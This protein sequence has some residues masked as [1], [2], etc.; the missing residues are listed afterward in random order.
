MMRMAMWV[1]L[2]AVD[3]QLLTDNDTMIRGEVF[4]NNPPRAA[5]AV[6]V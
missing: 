1:V 3:S 6:T 4:S 5:Q 2:L